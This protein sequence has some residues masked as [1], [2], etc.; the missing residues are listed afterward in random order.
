M[1]N[2]CSESA[3]IEP[4]LLLLLLLLV[5]VVVVVVE[6]VVVVVVVVVIV[7]L[8][9]I[10]NNYLFWVGIKSV[11]NKISMVYIEIAIPHQS[12]LIKLNYHWWKVKTILTFSPVPS[13]V[14]TNLGKI[15]HFLYLWISHTVNGKTN[16]QVQLFCKNFKLLFHSGL[17]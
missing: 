8:F 10:T 16:T 2:S 12:L 6:V 4:L 14:S 3:K 1:V 9:F 17:P 15:T 11:C 5:V 13:K 7:L